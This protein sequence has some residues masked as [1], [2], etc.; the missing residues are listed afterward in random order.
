MAPSVREARGAGQHHDERTSRQNA[1]QRRRG[2]QASVRP[3]R[4]REG[5]L[6]ALEDDALWSE[7]PVNGRPDQPLGPR[8]DLQLERRPRSLQGS[9]SLQLPRPRVHPDHRQPHHLPHA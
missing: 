6:H 9:P 8:V 7:R 2:Q 4:R 1:L 5:P 3:L